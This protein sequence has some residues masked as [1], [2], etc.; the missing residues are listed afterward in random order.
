MA[1]RSSEAAPADF[2]ASIAECAYFKAE[3]RGFAPGYELEDWLAA[4]REIAAT[5]AVTPMVAPSNG[6]TKRK[7]ARI[8]KLK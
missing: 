2:N 6:S 5:A 1:R 8:K 3:K 7:T 4:E